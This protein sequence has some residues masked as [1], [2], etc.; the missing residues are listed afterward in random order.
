VLSA[1]GF[2]YSL[3]LKSKTILLQ[4]K[5][6]FAYNGWV[7]TQKAVKGWPCVFARLLSKYRVVRRT[8]Y[9]K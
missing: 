9:I 6:T 5:K 7:F 1:D 2:L 4:Y 8:F 3:T